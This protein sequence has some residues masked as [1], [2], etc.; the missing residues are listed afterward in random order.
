[1]SLAIK[2]CGLKDHFQI[3]RLSEMGVAYVGINFY[4]HSKRF[5][6]ETFSLTILP[7]LTAKKVGI[8]V[9]APIEELIRTADWH[10]LDMI[11]LHG[12]ETAAYCEQVKIYLPVIKALP[13][14]K[15][16]D[17]AILNDYDMCDYYLFDSSMG[18]LA[19]LGIA[20][21]H[22]ILAEY[23]FD[24]PYFLAGGLGPEF[25]DGNFDNTLFPGLNGLDINSKFELSPGLK[26]LELI[27]SFIIKTQNQ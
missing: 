16:K 26:D 2:V 13:G 23:D 4:P 7:P 6:N 10:Q 20:F 22:T 8:F 24:K 5:Y 15:A 11:Q 9:D 17:K 21:D 18:K 27:A 1:M 19:G 25:L 12:N 3:R 14:I